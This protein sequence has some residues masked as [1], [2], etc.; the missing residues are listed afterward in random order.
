MRPRFRK[1]AKREIEE[2]TESCC[3]LIKCKKYVKKHNG[4]QQRE[5]NKRKQKMKN[6][7]NK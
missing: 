6:M 7:I 2:N 5:I 1:T 3:R 4:Y